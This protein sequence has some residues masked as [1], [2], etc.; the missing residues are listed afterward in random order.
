VFQ[1]KRSVFWEAIISVV[2]SKKG[3][4]YMCRIPNGF[5]DRAIS[6]YSTLYT[7][8]A[9]KTLWYWRC[10]FRKC[11]ILGKLYRLFH[12]NNIYRY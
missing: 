6:L 8:Q 7:V 12:L 4:M 10:N 1:E 2:I 11:I 3:Y 5:R 9:S